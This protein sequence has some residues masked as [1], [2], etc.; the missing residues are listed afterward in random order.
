MVVIP[1]HSQRNVLSASLCLR[2]GSPEPS[3]HRGEELMLSNFAEHAKSFNF[4][5]N[6]MKYVEL[7]SI[8][9]EGN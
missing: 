5:N 7:S 4:E 3:M 1:G 6:P 8:Y 2:A 9:E